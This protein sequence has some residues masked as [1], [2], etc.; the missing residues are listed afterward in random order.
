MKIRFLSTLIAVSAMLLVAAHQAGFRYNLTPSMPMGVYRFSNAPVQRNDMVAFTLPKKSPYAVLA[1]ERGYLELGH[2]RLVK[3]LVAVSG[4]HVSV[5]SG[6]LS[7]NGVLQPGSRA[8][9]HDRSGRSLPV[10]LVPG[11]VPPG[12]ALVLSRHLDGFDG[13]YFGLVDMA[14]LARV[15]PVFT[16]NKEFGNE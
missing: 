15:V 1:D 2:G 7:V 12:K 13:R 10:F 4:D 16:L 14:R 8:R 11:H 3:R 6:G 9:R 5:V